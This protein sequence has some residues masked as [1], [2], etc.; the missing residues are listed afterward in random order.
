VLSETFP[1][2]RY[3]RLD[4]HPADGFG[5]GAYATTVSLYSQDYFWLSTGTPLYPRVAQGRRQILTGDLLQLKRSIRNAQLRIRRATENGAQT[6]RDCGTWLSGPRSG[7]DHITTFVGR[8]DARTQ[9][10]FEF[11]GGQL[12]GQVSQG[13]DVGR[14][15]I[16]PQENM[17]GSLRM[18]EKPSTAAEIGVDGARRHAAERASH[19]L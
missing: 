17:L 6:T 5:A 1:T 12:D 13:N 19:P 10:G 8:S 11:R 3:E 2:G 16:E 18:P 4:E 15:P 14:G 9:K 7:R